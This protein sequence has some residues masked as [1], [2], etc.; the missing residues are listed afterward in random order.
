MNYQ[1]HYTNLIQKAQH[2]PSLEGY[3]EVHHI[4][5]KAFGGLDD[6]SN[7]VK[8]SARE[9][10]VAHRLLA[11]IYPD[12]GMVHA[13]WLMACMDKKKVSS[14]LYEHLRK[15]HARRVSENIEANKRKGRPGIKQSDNHIQ[16][17]K[18]SRMNNGKDWFSEETKLSISKSL[19]GKPSKRKGISFTEEQLKAHYKGVETRRQNGS[20]SWSEEQ[21]RKQS[22]TRTG[23]PGAPISEERK[24]EL[25]IEKSKVV[26]CPYCH[27]T[28]QCIIMYRWH[29]DNCKF[30]ENKNE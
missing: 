8:L 5:P 30:K 1:L 3:I 22:E 6:E 20:Y 16:S 17:R 27:K 24:R 19:K 2:R 7:L 14:R 13:I 10:F 15:E 18:E 12:S 23:K 21:K 25:S 4:V 26:E 28:G 11:K 29:F 9:H